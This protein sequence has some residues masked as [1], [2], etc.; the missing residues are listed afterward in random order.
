[1][2]K[3]SRKHYQDVGRLLGRSKASKKEVDSWCRTFKKDNKLFKPSLF[4]DWVKK[5]RRK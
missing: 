2:A 5:H 1:M 4:R 3:Y